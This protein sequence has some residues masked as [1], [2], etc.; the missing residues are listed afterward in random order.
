MSFHLCS[1]LTRSKHAFTLPAAVSELVAC[2]DFLAIVTVDC[3][4]MVIDTRKDEASVVPISISHLLNAPRSSSAKITLTEVMLRSNG[5]PIV[6]T[7]M[8]A[9]WA[10]DSAVKGWVQIASAWWGNSPLNEVRTRHSRGSAHAGPL[11][12]IE[13]RVAAGC[14]SSASTQEKPQW[15]KEYMSASHYESRMRACRLL[16]SKDEYKH[17]L[18]EYSKLLGEENFRERAE[19]LITELTGPLYQ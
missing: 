13:Q 12:E 16:D 4:V 5:C 8:P 6:I 18:R 15:W 19:E 11:A 1:Q 3:N 7:S 17:W 9:A 14:T 2:K 10:Y